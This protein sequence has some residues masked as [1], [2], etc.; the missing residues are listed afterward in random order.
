VGAPLDDAPIGPKPARSVSPPSAPSDTVGP[1]D[2]VAAPELEIVHT[3]PPLA[4]GPTGQTGGRTSVMPNFF[5]SFHAGAAVFDPTPERF[6]QGSAITTSASTPLLID[7]TPLSLG[8]ETVG[9]Y[10]DVLIP[11]NSPVPCEKTRTFL[12]ASDN[13][14]TVSIRVAQGESSRFAENTRLG[15]LELS[16]LRP[17][18]RGEV[19]IAVTFELD[20]DGI[21]NVRARDQDTGR[22]TTATIR[23]LGASTDAEDVRAMA[24]RQA[25]H[26]VA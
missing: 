23:L 18:R 10:S 24:E 19:K 11:A 15:D 5:E 20:A 14:T 2:I 21:L 16:G 1:S 17:A 4:M 12:T 26:V 13:Q 22:E 6:Q 8:V 9:G 3:A 7:V 25:R